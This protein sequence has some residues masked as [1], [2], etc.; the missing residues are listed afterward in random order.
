MTEE[1]APT[2][3][4]LGVRDEIVSAL[5]ADGIERTFP[6]QAQTLP[7]ALGGQDI[8]GQAKTGTGKTL[9]FGVPLLQRI[10][11]P[12]DGD[13]DGKPQALVVVP[14]R[15][16][17]IQ[18]G[19]DLEQAGAPLGI[20]VLTIYGGRAYEPQIEAL[21]A[22][23]EVVVGTPG[24]LIDLVTQRHLDLSAVRVLVLDEADEMLDMGFLPDVEKIVAKVP[25]ERQTMLFSATMPGQIVSLARRYM[26]RPMHIRAADI[27]DEAATVDAIEQ[28]VWRAHPMDKMEVVAR[29][30]QADGRGLTMIFT[31][32]KRRAQRIADELT[33]RGFAAGAVHGDLGQGA[34]EQALRAFRNGKIDVLAA[35]DVAA[36]GIDV[37]GVTHVI[38]YECPDDEKTYV[39]RIGRTG[40][41]GSS[42]VAVTLVDWED[43]ARWGMIDRALKLPFA[44]PIETYSTSEHVYTGLGIPTT[45]TGR[46]PRSART[47]EGLDAEVLEDLGETGKSRG[48]QSRTQSR[49]RG[50]SDDRDTQEKTGN[51]ANRKR[52]PRRRTRGGQSDAPTSGAAQDG[53]TQSSAA[54]NTSSADGDGTPRPRRRRRR[55]PRGGSQNSSAGSAPATE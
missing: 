49:S 39:H 18:V 34:R 43:L 16:L 7:L 44:D 4:E 20:R 23:I 45:A 42:G 28:H 46:L 38:N 41:A 51:S 27:G 22:G 32:T 53:G 6:I 10:Q 15:E 50:R 24:R 19:K 33:E 26:S 11:A 55:G 21:T 25:A 54:S 29:V 30:L 31:R 1:L 37:E 14:T 47:R 35:T 8:I 3:A 52:R 9:G 48:S 5:T 40:R 17:A 36:R 12:A 2:F 13:V